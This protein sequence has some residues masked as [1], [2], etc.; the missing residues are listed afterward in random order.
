[1]NAQT[2]INE[3]FNDSSSLDNWTITTENNG[4]TATI[5][6]GALQL[7][8][9]GGSDGYWGHSDYVRATANYSNLP[10]DF[11]NKEISFNLNEILISGVDDQKMSI[12][13]VFQMKQDDNNWLQIELS[14]WYS[15]YHPDPNFS[16]W[17]YYDTWNGHRLTMQYRINGESQEIFFQDLTLPMEYLNYD[18]KLINDNGVWFIYYKDSRETDY[19]LVNTNFNKTSDLQL[20]FQIYSGDGGFTRKNGAGTC[21]ADYF[22]VKEY[23][24]VLTSISTNDQTATVGR[25][26]E[27][28]VL[29]SELDSI[30]NV[31]AY[32]FDF[33]YDSA[34]LEYIGNSIVGTLAEDGALQV[35][36]TMN[37][38]SIAWARETPIIGE[39]AI[40]N[41]QFK[42]I[43]AG[44]ITPIITNALYNTGTVNASNGIITASYKYGDID[45]NDHVQAY[46]AAL[47]IQYSLG[48]DPIPEIDPL[49]WENW[50]IVT[51]N[52]DGIGGVTAND[53]SEILKHTVGLSNQFPVE[54]TMNP[55]PAA[56]ADISVSVE[57]GE[58]VLTSTGELF[59]LNVFVN[60]NF[61]V[62][63]KPENFVED[64]LFASDI[65][66]TNYAFA[67]ATA[68]SPEDNANVV[69]I[70]YSTTQDQDIT[71]DLI[72][73]TEFRSF[74]IGLT[75]GVVTLN[76]QSVIL[77][78]NPA[79]N[80]LY[81]SGVE[82]AN[83]S[84]FD[85]NGR[86]V[87]NQ[88]NVSNQIDV[89]TLPKGMYSVKIESG[90]ESITRK[91][92]KN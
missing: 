54:D 9:V 43:D 39:G 40:L 90:N 29:T 12:S 30:A 88:S 68:Y 10:T 48:L 92:I 3:L 36:P 79:E 85:L 60:E 65:S 50:R 5:V 55:S 37:N 71:L 34:K 66:D 21:S 35:N 14:G 2:I 52:V 53:A 69:K 74:T 64:A 62:L 46:D 28:P 61:S 8:T 27:I 22:T 83:V 41:L 87:L 91:L 7:H 56:K 47:A 84:I 4:G 77:Y 20:S 23:T 44:A 86:N 51:A 45:A 26:I 13:S 63:G 42:V 19:K 49:P 57:N 16:G 18:F 24:P 59:G 67:L 72:V 38:L 58:I 82:N 25:I 80:V 78:P 75:T 1:M 31:I 70:P 73:N 17:T 89:S 32:Q 76:E 33:E 81:L 15:S 11:T 6:D